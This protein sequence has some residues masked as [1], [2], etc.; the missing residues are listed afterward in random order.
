MPIQD[1][2]FQL[3]LAVFTFAFGACFGSLINVIAYRVPLGLNIVTPPSRCPACETRL[4]WRENIPIFGWMI[5]GGKCRFCKSKI[6]PEYPIVEAVVAFLFLLFYA[7]WY[8]L[9]PTF[10]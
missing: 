9:P 5:L 8:L 10:H 2:L 6:S 3:P 4:T 7:V 1:V